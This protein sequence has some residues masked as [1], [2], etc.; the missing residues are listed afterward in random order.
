MKRRKVTA[1]Q[2]ARQAGVS[3]TTVSFVLNDVQAGNISEAT[4][5]RV[6][7]AARELNYVPDIA[8]RSLA[9]GRSSNIALVLG[10]PHQQ[11][12]IDEYIPKILTGIRAA[13]QA[14]GYRIMVEMVDD[15]ADPETYTRLVRGQEVAGMIVSLNSPTPADLEHL[16]ACTAQ[17]YPL[18]ALDNYPQVFAVKVDKLMGVRLAAQHLIDLGHQRIACITYAPAGNTHS[19]AR[20]AT[21]ADELHHAG[22]EFDASL[23]RY[24]AYDPETGYAAMQSL[25]ERDPLPTALFAMNDVMAFGAMQ[26]IY[27]RG[28]RIPED[29]AVVGFDDMRLAAYATPPLTT[30]HEPDVEHGRL[31]GEMLMQLIN[32]EAPPASHRTLPTRLIVRQSCGSHSQK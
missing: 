28:L 6:L 10:K 12:F 31:A 17:G 23:V 11:V 25:L 1:S 8:A 16:A 24:G 22:L 30:V 18:V 32:G 9:R 7:D 29:I 14:H 20:V 19:D 4:R 2:V 5:Q 27:E 26:A 21:F 15:G 13:T 3:P